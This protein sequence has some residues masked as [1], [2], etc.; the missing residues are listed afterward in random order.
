[1]NDPINK[2]IFTQKKVDSRISVVSKKLAAPPPME[3]NHCEGNS[4]KG[5][6]QDSPTKPHSSYHI[7]RESPVSDICNLSAASSFKGVDYKSLTDETPVHNI[8]GAPIP[9]HPPAEITC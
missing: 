1:M 6:P 3:G 9:D 8:V 4:W 5:D 2:S 7:I